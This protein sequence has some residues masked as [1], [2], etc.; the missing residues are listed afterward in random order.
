M[1][2]T[3]RQSTFNTAGRQSNFPP[4]S[5]QRSSTP[6]PPFTKAGDGQSNGANRADAT[7]ITPAPKATRKASTNRPATSLATLVRTADEAR[8]AVALLNTLSR[9]VHACDTETTGVDPTAESPVG[10]GRVICISIYSGPFVD[11]SSVGETIEVRDSTL[12]DDP[13][14]GTAPAETAAASPAESES[15]TAVAA[16]AAAAAAAGPSGDTGGAAGRRRSS[17]LWIDT[18]GAEREGVWA[19]LRPWLE[20][21]RAKKVTMGWDGME[22]IGPSRRHGIDG[23]RLEGHGE[24]TN[25]R[26]RAHNTS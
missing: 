26:A 23:S 3:K 8:R 13:D 15:S 21:P 10:K 6:R 12:P 20:N 24:E 18:N 16:A 14:E 5:T 25:R 1:P 2:P 22:G 11:F 4:T 9:N 7:I 17:R 19:E